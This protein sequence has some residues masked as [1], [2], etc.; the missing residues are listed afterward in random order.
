MYGVRGAGV[1]PLRGGTA[2]TPPVH[3][4]FVKAVAIL[5]GL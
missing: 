1:P 5:N 4:L 2:P 3:I